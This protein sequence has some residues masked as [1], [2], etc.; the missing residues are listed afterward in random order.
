[1]INGVPYAK[2]RQWGEENNQEDNNDEQ[3]NIS[4]VSA[5]YLP[6]LKGRLKKNL[7]AYWL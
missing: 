6:A 3:Q 4:V 1:M 2:N 5:K 7:C